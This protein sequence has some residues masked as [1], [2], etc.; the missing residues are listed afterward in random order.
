[1]FS[2]YDVFILRICVVSWMLSWFLRYCS[3]CLQSVICLLRFMFVLGGIVLGECFLL[4]R[5]ISNVVVSF[6]LLALALFLCLY[7]I[8]VY[9]ML[10]GY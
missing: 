4:A 5:V 7:Y 9:S 2:L 3:F 6:L 10:V 8:T 1:M